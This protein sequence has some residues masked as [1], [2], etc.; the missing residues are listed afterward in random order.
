MVLLVAFFRRRLTPRARASIVRALVILLFVGELV[1][2]ISVWNSYS[3]NYLPFH[4]SSTYYVSFALYAFGRGRVKHYG[5]CTSYIGGVFLFVTMT[6]NPHSVVGDTAE[7][8]THFYHVHSYFYHMAVLL[9][10]LIMLFGEDYRVRRFDLLRYSTFLG[11]WAAGAIPAAVRFEVNYAGLLRSFILPLEYI[12]LRFGQVVYLLL[13]AAFALIA[14][15][16]A[17][18]ICRLVALLITSARAKKHARV[19]ATEE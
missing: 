6:V 19:T 9:L 10:W 1:K 13:Y 17:L 4:Y 5:A 12:R 18:G 8:L 15:A 2:Q 14:A 16:L 3:P 7:M 11:M